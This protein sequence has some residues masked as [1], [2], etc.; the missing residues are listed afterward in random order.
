MTDRKP[1]WTKNLGSNDDTTFAKTKT[2]HFFTLTEIPK[3]SALVMVQGKIRRGD[4]SRQVLLQ[5]PA[6]VNARLS[7]DINGALGPGIVGLLEYALDHLE[8]SKKTILI[9]NEPD[10]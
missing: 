10:K 6:S 1:D 3:Q 7:S 8:K 5:L 4:I 9:E 2:R